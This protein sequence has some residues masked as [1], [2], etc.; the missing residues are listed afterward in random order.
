MQ[1][2]AMLD[3]HA[4][5]A[6]GRSRGV[7]DIA[8]VVGREPG[9][10]GGEA[11]CRLRRDL[12]GGVEDNDAPAKRRGHAG[13]KSSLAQEHRD[14]G[15]LHHVANALGGMR[16]IDRHIGGAGLQAGQ[17]GDDRQ[18]RALERQADQ[19]TRTGTEPPEVV[20]KPVGARLQLGIGPRCCLADQRDGVAARIDLRLEQF[21]QKG[22]CAGLGR[23]QVGQLHHG[24]GAGA[25]VRRIA[26]VHAVGSKFAEGSRRRVARY[27][28]SFVPHHRSML[29]RTTVGATH[30]PA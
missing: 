9:S 14:L 12:L 22:G 10:G 23:C 16:R 4:L 29:R 28:A 24:L 1:R 5:G 2:I 13:D 27:T 11:R 3:H 26:L 8:E 15:F 19:R 20:G 30:K 6:A 7:D 17:D 21:V 18:L 25:F